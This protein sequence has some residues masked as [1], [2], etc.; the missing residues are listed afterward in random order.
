MDCTNNREYLD[1][2]WSHAFSDSNGWRNEAGTYGVEGY[3]IASALDLTC[4]SEPAKMGV[5]THEYLHTFDLIDM[6][7]YSFEGKG[8][9][10]FDIMAYPYGF[11]NDGYIPVSLSVWAKTAIDW[12]Q[13]E[14]VTTS[15]MYTLAPAALGPNCYRITLLSEE[16]SGRAEYLL[17]ENRQQLAFDVDFWESGIV[18]YHIDDAASE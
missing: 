2:I 11:N 16:E 17:L 12:L 4:D 9:G 6:Y 1:R 18:M 7:D 13:C 8:V 3:M 10:Q 14:E 15:G 5:M